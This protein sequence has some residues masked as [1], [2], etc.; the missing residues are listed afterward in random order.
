MTSSHPLT[1]NQV[2]IS[3]RS[4]NHP[5]FPF[6]INQ[7]HCGPRPA[8]I[9]ALSLNRVSTRIKKGQHITFR[10]GNRKQEF[11]SY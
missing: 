10:G 9:Y 1:G 6:F 8:V 3:V 7:H 2:F 4:A 5:V 11:L